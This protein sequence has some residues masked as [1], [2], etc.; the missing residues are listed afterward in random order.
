M[1]RPIPLF[2]EL[3]KEYEDN[4]K[5]FEG[6]TAIECF[7]TQAQRDAGEP[8]HIVHPGFLKAGI[9]FN[10]N[11]NN[12]LW[13][14]IKNDKI[15]TPIT[16]GRLV[17]LGFERAIPGSNFSYRYPKM[18]YLFSLNIDNGTVTIKNDTRGILYYTIAANCDEARLV[19]F[20]YAITGEELVR[21]PNDYLSFDKVRIDKSDYAVDELGKF[22]MSDLD[23]LKQY[24]KRLE[25]ERDAIGINTSLTHDDV[26]NAGWRVDRN[27]TGTPD[28][29]IYRTEE[30]AS[31]KWKCGVEVIRITKYDRFRSEM[32]WVPVFSG[33]IPTLSDLHTIMRL[34]NIK[35]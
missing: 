3:I 21:L 30:D 2:S 1:K 9:E 25:A 18:S 28:Y 23:I 4:P 11:L 32:G 5:K 33:L 17:E 31:F 8:P 27:G 12:S 35:A 7:L 13:L 24:K 16:H 10:N 34:L 6:I 22:D 20:I 29:Y 26:V 14:G 15:M 19:A